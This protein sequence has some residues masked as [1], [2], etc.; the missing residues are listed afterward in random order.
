MR[1]IFPNGNLQY[2]KL[3]IFAEKFNMP[4]IVIDTEEKSIDDIV[5][6]IE[7][8]VIK[9]IKGEELDER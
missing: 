4:H 8:K 6:E 3:C 7:E 1:G 2:S 5:Q 9:K